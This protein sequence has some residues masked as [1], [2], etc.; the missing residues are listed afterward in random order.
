MSNLILV[1]LH[2][3]HN[4]HPRGALSQTEAV[5]RKSVGPYR[6]TTFL[7]F[8][9]TEVKTLHHPENLPVESRLSQMTCG[10][11]SL[12]KV[13]NVMQD[14]RYVK[15]P[16]GVPNYIAD[17]MK[18][19][20]R[21]YTDLQL[22]LEHERGEKVAEKRRRRER[23]EKQKRLEMQLS[24]R[25][26]IETHRLSI[27]EAEAESGSVSKGIR[28]KEKDLRSLTRKADELKNEIE[29]LERKS[30]QLS[31]KTAYVMRDV[32]PELW[33]TVLKNIVGNLTVYKRFQQQ[34]KAEP[35]FCE[36]TPPEHCREMFLTKSEKEEVESLAEMQKKVC[37]E[38]TGRLEA[39]D[40]VNLDITFVSR[41]ITNSNELLDNIYLRLERKRKSSAALQKNEVE[42][43]ELMRSSSVRKDDSDSD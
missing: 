28:V 43:L 20:W 40:R 33:D 24:L 2:C 8:L 7:V 15:T 12:L 14:G 34:M 10:T 35:H 18:R 9:S 39:L 36:A 1:L 19:T 42:L 30:E 23:I 16:Q 17:P 3:D 32:P 29:K 25:E 21:N 26:S 38:I 6:L 5:V 27:L 22:S 37:H 11:E 31:R 4:L 41:Q 13:S